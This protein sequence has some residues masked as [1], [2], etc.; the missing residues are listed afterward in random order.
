MKSKRTILVLLI[1]CIILSIPLSTVTEAAVPDP[2]KKIIAYYMNWSPYP[3]QQ[4]HNPADLPWDKLTHV[5]YAF[6]D[7]DGTTGTLKF[8]DEIADTQILFG[9]EPPDLPYYGNFNQ[10]RLQK[11]NHPDVKVLISV[12]GWTLSKYFSDVALTNAS[13]T[14]FANS[15]VDFLRTYDFFDGIDID[16]EYPVSGGEPDNIYRPEDKQN[17][18]LLMQK[19]RSVL[20]TAGAQDGKYY[21]LTAA[22]S[23]SFEK[24]PNYEINK[25]PQ[26]MDFMIVMGYDFH[27]KWENVT[28]HC[29]PLYPL[30]GDIQTA[31]FK[32]KYNTDWAISEYIRNNVPRSKIILGVPFFSQGWQNVAPG[33]NGL[34]VS[35]YGGAPDIWGD[36]SGNIPFWYLKEM[37]ASGQYTKFRDPI[38]KAPW[39][40]SSTLGITHTYED[41]I[42]FSN[43]LDYINGKNIGGVQWWASAYDYPKKTGNTLTDIAYNKFVGVPDNMILNPGF[44]SGLANWADWGNRSVVINSAN[45]N[46]GSHFMRV[47]TNES[48]TGQMITTNVSAGNQYTFRAFGKV[49]GSNEAGYIGVKC[50]N[51]QNQ[52]LGTF[53]VDAYTE[54]VYT[55]KSMTFTAPPGTTKLQP[56]M[57][58]LNGNGYLYGDDFVLYKNMILNPGFEQQNASWVDW[59]SSGAVSGVGSSGSYGMRVGTGA[60]GRGQE[61]TAG[62]SAGANYTL[63][64]WCKVSTSSETGYIGVKCYNSSNEEIGA[65]HVGAVD[66]VYYT[67]KYI[68]FTAPAGT[69]KLQPYIWKNSGNG[70][71]YVDD[72]ELYRLD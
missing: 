72:M 1:T 43:K 37:E 26:Y 42:S 40:Y 10:I 70:Y 4:E 68:T 27:G 52:E 25:Y 39:I 33:A 29:T 44:E 47:G 53:S 50:L 21:M 41:E 19:L 46:S 67:Q 51:D 11:L 5:L 30:A 71:L 2:S 60:G 23:A 54:T 16:W 3:D 22:V 6:M 55:L 38:S 59:G 15:C 12:G 66:N 69:V 13:R 7:I 62:V 63:N 57:Y 35:A 58:K 32:E 20:N 18:T 49:S 34:F 48:G 14:T 28:N 24:M 45:A 61:I 9:G 17:Y 65:F 31:E 56:Y 64:A 36:T 8:Y